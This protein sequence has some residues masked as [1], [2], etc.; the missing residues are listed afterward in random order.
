MIE[1]QPSA[2]SAYS[3]KT[4]GQGAATSV[5][6]GLVAPADA[7]GARCCEDCDVAEV[8]DDP[9]ASFGVRSHALDAEHARALWLKSEEMVREPFGP[10]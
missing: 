10:R 1:A 8:I 5:W 4:G 9:A 3:W 7:V 6:A 2:A